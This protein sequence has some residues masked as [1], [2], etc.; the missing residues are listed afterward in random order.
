MFP[1]WL[2][3]QLKC[4]LSQLSFYLKETEKSPF[5]DYMTGN[6]TEVLNSDFFFLQHFLKST[7]IILSL[8]VLP[9]LT[10]SYKV[11]AQGRLCEKH[12]G[13]QKENILTNDST[14]PDLFNYGFKVLSIILISSNASS[15]AENIPA[16]IS[17]TH[18]KVKQKL[19][20][21]Y[22]EGYS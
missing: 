17:V 15:W 9:L 21:I 7:D 22:E 20:T 4:N 14:A 2:E 6:E 3:K 12:L 5:V 1:S 16:C 19:K 8:L 18:R 10:L 11:T 13:F